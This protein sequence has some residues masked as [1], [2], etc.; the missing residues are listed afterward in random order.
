MNLGDVNFLPTV[1]YSVLKSLGWT[2]YSKKDL[3]WVYSA[4][5]RGSRGRGLDNLLLL[6]L[7][8]VSLPLPSSQRA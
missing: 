6:F 4:G 8:R 5:V 3:T 2:T 1:K 7:Q